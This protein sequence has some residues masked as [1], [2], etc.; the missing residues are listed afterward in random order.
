MSNFDRNSSFSY[1]RGVAR[2]TTLEIDQ[3]LRAYMLGV[4]NY[5]TLGLGV[6]GLVALGVYML[7]VTKTGGVTELT[8]FGAAI[9]R[10]PIFFLLAFAPVGFVFYLSA[11][12][13][14]ISA[15]TA[16]NVFLAFAALMG[17]SLSVLLVKFTGMSVARIFFIT[18]AAFSGLSLYGYTTKRDLSGFGA[19]LVMGV[20]GLLIAGVVNMFLL[21]SGLQFAM[22]IISVLVF[23]GLTAWDTQSIKDMYLA[24]EGYEAV[25]KKSIYGALMLYM[26]F[27]VMFQNLLYLMGDRNE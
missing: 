2:P 6:T 22:S 7:A 25:Q 13:N 20:W 16:R 8:P 24:D 17:V 21:S 4:Y 26:D 12:L 1:G 9:F 15:A 10:G 3:G 23:A 14:R 5:M 27:I 18:A 19:F 11:S